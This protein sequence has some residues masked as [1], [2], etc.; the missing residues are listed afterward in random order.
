MDGMGRPFSGFVLLKLE[1]PVEGQ[2]AFGGRFRPEQRDA[3]RHFRW[4]LEVF[5]IRIT[6]MIAKWGDQ[7]SPGGQGGTMGNLAHEINNLNAEH[8]GATR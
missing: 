7:D 8:R 1:T 5:S 4:M 3:A 2:G 6:Y